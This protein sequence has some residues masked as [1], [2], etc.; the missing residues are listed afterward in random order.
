VECLNPISTGT[1]AWPKDTP[2]SITP[3]SARLPGGVFL[4]WEKLFWVEAEIML[5]PDLTDPNLDNNKCTWDP[6]KTTNQPYAVLG[7]GPGPYEAILWTAANYNGSHASVECPPTYRQRLLPM[8]PAALMDFRG[9][10]TLGS[11]QTG[12]RIG[13]WGW[14]NPNFE[15]DEEFQQPKFDP[16]IVG[17]LPRGPN[18]GD[19]QG[20]IASLILI[21]DFDSHPSR[22]PMGVDI[23]AGG[24][25]TSYVPPVNPMLPIWPFLTGDGSGRA[26]SYARF[27]PLPEKKEEK[28]AKYADLGRAGSNA[29]SLFLMPNENGLEWFKNDCGGWAVVEL[30]KDRNFAGASL[31]VPSHGWYYPF[32]LFPKGFAYQVGSLKVRWIDK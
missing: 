17:P 32:S 1:G 3:T 13:I 4:E 20:K 12:A 14:K 15:S 30:Y 27:F 10:G 5:P 16:P 26:Y 28:E 11:I 23:R 29:D 22:I 8:L 18:L 7:E 6:Q 25:I 2:A 9:Q 31:V 19:R 21:P 24:T